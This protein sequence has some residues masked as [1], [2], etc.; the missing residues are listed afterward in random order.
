MLK[1]EGHGGTKC[2]H[3]ST[4]GG[5]FLTCL[6]NAWMH[7][8]NGKCGVVYHLVMNTP[9]KPMT[10]GRF[11]RPIFMTDDRFYR[12]TFFSEYGGFFR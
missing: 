6:W 4:L 12:T 8:N 2:G 7:L 3:V 9:L 11:Y 5:I 1:G 10:D